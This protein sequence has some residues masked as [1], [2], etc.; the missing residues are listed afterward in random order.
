MVPGDLK[1]FFRE[2]T[3]EVATQCGSEGFGVPMVTCRHPAWPV[4]VEGESQSPCPAARCRPPCRP[5]GSPQAPGR[6]GDSTQQPRPSPRTLALSPLSPPTR[7]CFRGIGERRSGTT[8]THSF[9]TAPGMLKARLGAGGGEARS[10]GHVS[11]WSW[12][13][14]HS[15]VPIPSHRPCPSGLWSW[16]Y[17]HLLCAGF[18]FHEVLT[19]EFSQIGSRPVGS[20]AASC[21]MY[22]GSSSC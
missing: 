11:V 7:S 18:F 12:A 16:P 5:G 17:A 19:L 6:H 4:H 1:D 14:G 21:S 20:R 3:K 9:K 22:A 10:R 13:H 15:E 2:Q 8:R